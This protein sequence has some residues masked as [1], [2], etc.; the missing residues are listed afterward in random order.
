MG[1]ASARQLAQELDARRVYPDGKYHYRK[2]DKIIN[3][4]NS[5]TPEWVCQDALDNMLN[6]PYN[7]GLASNKL[8]TL[9]TL[10]DCEVP[11]LEFTTNPDDIL[12]WDFVFCR[13]KLTGHSGEGIIVWE[14]GEIPP[15]KL[16]TKGVENH[17]EYR[18]HVFKGEVIDYRKKS[19]HREDE[20]TDFESLI[21]TNDNGWLFRQDNLKRLERIETL[22]IRAIDALGLD[23]GCVDIIKDE[24]GN[25][26]VCEVNTAFGMETRT[27]EVYKDKFL[28]W[29]I[30]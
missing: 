20:A 23:F 5:N 10:Q 11:C 26:V 3:W 4:G 1:S 19:R 29:M 22:A 30:E 6:K 15:A 17:G 25:V 8:K 12:E 16:Y 21:R 7:V 2:G 18:L 27:I 28:T 13:Q 9:T 14:G 24:N